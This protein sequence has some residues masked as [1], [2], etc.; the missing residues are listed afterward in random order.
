MLTSRRWCPLVVRHRAV[1]GGDEMGKQK[2]GRRR[3]E[4]PD[5]KGEESVRLV[6]IGDEDAGEMGG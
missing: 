4:K 3:R 2:R 1:V 5:G 6:L